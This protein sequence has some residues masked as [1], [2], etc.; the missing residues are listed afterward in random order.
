[1]KNNLHFL[2]IHSLIATFASTAMENELDLKEYNFFEKPKIISEITVIKEPWQAEYLAED[3]ILVNGG[4]GCCIINPITNEKIKRIDI[5]APHFAI[6]P[7]T[8]KIAF[9]GKN[10]AIYSNSGDLETRI[11]SYPTEAIKKLA[12]NPLYGRILLEHG[13]FTSNITEYNYETCTEITTTGKISHIAF[14]PIQEIIYTC[15]QNQKNINVYNSAAFSFFSQN[16]IDTIPLSHCSNPNNILCSPHGTLIAV[17]DKNKAVYII[18]SNDGIH[19]VDRIKLP[20]I[21]NKQLCIMNPITDTPTIIKLDRNPWRCMQFHPNSAVLATVMSLY[22]NSE[23]HQIVFYWN[24]L[25]QQ[26]ITT[27]PP[28]PS[29]NNYNITFSLNGTKIIVVL[30]DKCII[31]PVPFEVIYNATEKLPYL[32]WFLLKEC[33]DQHNVPKDIQKIIALYLLETKFKR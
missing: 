23:P 5:L 1:M 30:A 33:L 3:R 10:S 27:T 13:V 12:F 6:H 8:K 2:I 14:H 11:Q 26:L 15:S 29:H 32:Y 19:T 28:F 25:T 31:L 16:L 18:E 7:T 20:T 24:A 4:D 21:K 22:I 9:A 17:E